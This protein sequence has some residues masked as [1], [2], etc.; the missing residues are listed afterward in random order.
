MAASKTP[1]RGNLSDAQLEQKREQKREK[2]RAHDRKSQQI[3]RERTRERIKTLEQQ[4][5]EL[6]EAK[7]QLDKALQCNSELEAQIAALQRQVTLLLMD[8]QRL[9]EPEYMGIAPA[10][11]TN[12]YIMPRILSKRIANRGAGQ[13]TTINVIPYQYTQLPQSAFTQG[14]PGISVE[15]V[16][17]SSLGQY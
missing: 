7:E 5:A 16:T 9:I 13:N 12:N 6:S 15:M 4:V 10:Y 8:G 11:G 1:R 2:K 14:Q 3:I 17:G